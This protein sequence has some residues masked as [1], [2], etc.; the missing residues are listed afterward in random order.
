M[1]VSVAKTFFFLSDRTYTLLAFWPTVSCLL[2]RYTR[3]R[4]QTTSIGVG[5]G[6]GVGGVHYYCCFAGSLEMRLSLVPG[7]GTTPPNLNS[8]SRTPRA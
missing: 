5:V 2:S 4:P 8:R 1:W 6:V 3:S 7:P